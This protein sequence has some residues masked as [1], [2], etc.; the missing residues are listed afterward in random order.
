MVCV[1]VGMGVDTLQCSV[2]IGGI[3]EAVTYMSRLKH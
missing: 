2:I 3:E 1:T